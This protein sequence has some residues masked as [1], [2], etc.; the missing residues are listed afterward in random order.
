MVRCPVFHKK[1]NITKEALDN[2]YDRFNKPAFIHP[3]PL[4]VVIRYNNV[5]D[6]EIVGLIAASLAYGRVAQIIRSVNR[7]VEPLGKSPADFILSV[8]DSE[9]RNILPKFKHR[10]TSGE[11]IGAMLVGI[12]RTLAEFGSLNECFLDGY[13]SADENILL[14]LEGFVGHIARGFPGGC[15]YL[16]PSPRN[17]SACKRMNLYLKWM[18][19]KDAVDPGGWRG[20]S[21]SKLIVPVDSHMHRIGL[22]IGLTSRKSADLKTAIEITNAFKRFAPDDPTK[23]DFAITRLGIRRDEDPAEFIASMTR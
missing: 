8:T 10:F 3:D 13:S 2:I 1:G 17:G 12:K 15:S 20:V 18:V 5:S 23:Y 6:R 22:A 16:L 21:P 4:E 14:G 9:L 7:A 11:E 19:R